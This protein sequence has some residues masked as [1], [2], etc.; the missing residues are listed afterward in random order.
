MV[1]NVV[2]IFWGPWLNISADIMLLQLLILITLFYIFFTKNI[3][4]TVLYFFLNLFYSGI[5]LCIF[6]LDL[7]TGF[8][9]LIECT[10]IFVFIL[11][12]FFL[13]FKGFLTNFNFKNFIFNKIHI[14]ILF[15]VGLT[16]FTDFESC[17]FNFNL[18]DV[19]DDYYESICNFR[20]NDFFGLFLS[21]Y[22][23][24]SLEFIITGF[25]LLIGS[26]MCIVIFKLNKDIR[27]TPYNSFFSFFDF[28]K[29]SISY[30]FMR[31]QNAINQNKVAPAT[32]VF[33]K[34]KI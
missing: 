34:K 5:F 13:N 33:K 14:I 1:L 6:Q 11:L 25:L 29:E 18:F 7:F 22:T 26:V 4:Y 27:I 20:M 9:W 30:I 3:Y 8:L 16:I 12:L 17:L 24:N 19:W 2:N 21:Y 32:R 31:K 28:F 23:F 15:L 10:V